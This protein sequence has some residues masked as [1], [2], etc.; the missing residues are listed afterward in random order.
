MV[1]AF[2]VPR[3]DGGSVRRHFADADI[4]EALGVVVALRHRGPW[5]LRRLRPFKA[6]TAP[7]GA[8]EIVIGQ[9]GILR[10]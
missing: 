4:G 2:R 5:H 9:M 7:D 10:V 8:R 6:N 3:D 1:I